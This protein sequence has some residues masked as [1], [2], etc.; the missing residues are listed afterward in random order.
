ML[1]WFQAIMPKE[2]K[3]FTLFSDH[4][5]TLVEGANALRDIMKGGD[6]VAEACARVVAHEDAADH[7]TRE[8]LLNVRRTFITPFDR[9]DIKDLITS[10]D[11]AIDQMQKTAKVVTLFE[12]REF[13]DPMRE[14]ADIIVEAALLTREAVG[15]M[16]NMR[17]NVTRLNQL[18]EQITHIEDRSDVIYDA[19]RKALFL[20]HRH[21]DPM[22]FVVGVDLYSHLEKVMDRFEDVANRISGIVIEQV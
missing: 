9:G 5:E 7:I 20:A 19:G 18:T 10:L 4:A 11:D 15:L 1:S 2:L 6:G 16:A 22:A 3:F 8:V 13:E 17:Q 12:L 21:D 14:M